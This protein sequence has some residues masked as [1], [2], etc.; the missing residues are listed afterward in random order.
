MKWF[1]APDLAA[2]KAVCADI[3]RAFFQNPTYIPL[4][5]YYDTTAYKRITGLRMGFV[6][7]YDVKPA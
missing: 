6:Q 2:Q 4:G 3:Q 7:F 5:A 1:Q